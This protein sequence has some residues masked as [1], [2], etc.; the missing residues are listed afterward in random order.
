MTASLFD[1]ISGLY[2]GKYYNETETKDDILKKYSNVLSKE[3][4][5]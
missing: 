5:N 4:I 2:F 3:T 1:K